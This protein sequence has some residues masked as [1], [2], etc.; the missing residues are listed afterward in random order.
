[1]TRVHHGSYTPHKAG[2]IPAQAPRSARRQQ[3]WL[4][5]FAKVENGH[6]VPFPK[7][8]R[9]LRAALALLVLSACSLASAADIV[10]G[11][12]LYREHCASCHGS[13]GRPVMIGAPD[14]SQPT[15]LLKPDMN[16][17]QSIRA[18]RGA[19]PAYQGLLRDREVLDI[20]AHLRTL[21]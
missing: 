6:G 14:F 10:K 4:D 13:N 8:D 16:L 12:E 20:V 18:G 1:M 15:A 7:P 19:M 21:R 5:C 9:H 2:A 3:R 11:A 17:L